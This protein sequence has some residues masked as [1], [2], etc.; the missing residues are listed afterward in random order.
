MCRHYGGVLITDIQI[1]EAEFEIMKVL[2]AAP[3][4]LTTGDIRGRLDREWERTTVLTLLSRL[5]EKGAVSAEKD[6]RSYLYKSRITRD[7][8]G[9]MKTQSILN[10]IYNGSIKSMLAALGDAR[11]LTE[12]DLRELEEIL[13]R[14][15]K[16]K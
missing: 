16:T 9:V 4:G 14:G 1:S 11:G 10:R 15:D 5:T 2:W 8:Y 13:D 7:E 6:N 3:E 12:S